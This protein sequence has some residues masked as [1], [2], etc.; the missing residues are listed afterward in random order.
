MDKKEIVRQGYNKVAES[1]QKTSGLEKEGLNLLAN[2]TSRIP[3]VGRVL[4]A[5]CGNGV[6]SCFLS[7]DF[8]VIGVDISEK[9]IE[10]ARH[11]APKAEFICEDMTKISFPEEYFDGILS[12]YA[13]IHVPR[14]EHFDLLRNFY[15]MLKFNGV[16]LL[17]FQLN[18]DPESYENNFF[19]KGVK[20]YWSGFDKNENL[21]MLKNAG[22]KII[23]AKS[24]QESPKWGDSS[25]LYV[26][27]EK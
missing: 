10:L 12:Y 5:G 13:I 18:A 20:M 21:N 9:Q 23:W 8:K 1:L 25:H 24:I 3:Q 19:H 22:F 17:I 16:V 11:N 26:F 15:R 7:D 6:Y 4:D 14:E 27:A 2:F